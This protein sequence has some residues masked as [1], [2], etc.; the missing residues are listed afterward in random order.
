MEDIGVADT[1]M[2]AVAGVPM[3]AE[4][5]RCLDCWRWDGC[6]GGGGRSGLDSF[7]ERVEVLGLLK[8]TTS[9]VPFRCLE[10]IGLSLRMDFLW[11]SFDKSYRLTIVGTTAPEESISG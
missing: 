6:S 4:R 9:V 10:S 2:D 8:G 1:A 7:E 3:A 5:C 11:P